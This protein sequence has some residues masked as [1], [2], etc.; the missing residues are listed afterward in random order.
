MTMTGFTKDRCTGRGQGLTAHKTNQV[1]ERGL[2]T[3][4]QYRQIVLEFH[5]DLIPAAREEG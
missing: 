1:I 5:P 2:C 4:S 3:M